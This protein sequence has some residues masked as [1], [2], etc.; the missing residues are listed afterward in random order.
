[1]IRKIWFYQNMRED[2]VQLSCT[3]L[4]LINIFG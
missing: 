3:A 1:M 4:D 2:T